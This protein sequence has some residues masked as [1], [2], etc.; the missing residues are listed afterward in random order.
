QGVYVG[1]GETA[2]DSL[3]KAIAASK[4]GD[5][6]ADKPLV[7][8]LS[9]T[10][11][12]KLIS[13]GDKNHRISAILANAKLEPGTDI[14]RIEERIVKNGAAV[15]IEAEEGVFKLIGAAASVAPPALP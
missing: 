5:T 10:R 9:L 3:K 7:A 8:T 4:E 1:L 14:I 2:V 13:K 12:L 15:R 6:K 11:L